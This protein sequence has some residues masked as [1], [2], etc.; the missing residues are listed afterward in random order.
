[1]R[2]GCCLDCPLMAPENISVGCC[3]SHSPP[4]L[5]EMRPEHC[6]NWSSHKARFRTLGGGSFGHISYGSTKLSAENQDFVF[7]NIQHTAIVRDCLNPA[8][9]FTLAI[10]V[11]MR[12]SAYSTLLLAE[13]MRV[14]RGRRESS[15]NWRLG[16]SLWAED[17]SSLLCCCC[18]SAPYTQKVWLFN[19]CL[20]G[21]VTPARSD[22]PPPFPVCLSPQ[23]DIDP[24]GTFSL[25][26]PVDRQQAIWVQGY[27]STVLLLWLLS[28]LHTDEF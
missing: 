4:C 17:C 23:G 2:N 18:C 3:A 24:G 9:D 27:C 6:V 1:M 22:P 15:A 16:R 26:R 11:A 10:T 19:L 5:K 7:M 28:P 14:K 13:L 21:Q 25:L 8:K 12:V 20:D